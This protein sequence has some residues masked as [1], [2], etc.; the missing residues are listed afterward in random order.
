MKTVPSIEPSGDRTQGVGKRHPAWLL[1]V[2]VIGLTALAWS[3]RFVLDDAFI[4]LRYARNLARGEGLVWNAGEWVEGYTNFAWT[5]W[6]ALPFQLGVDPVLFSQL[7][8]LATFVVS[9]VAVWLAARA[10]L[11]DSTGALVAV[12]TLGMTP[13]FS[14]YATGGLETSLQAGLLTMAAALALQIW[15]STEVTPRSAAMLSATLGLAV[16][17]RMDS[18]VIGAWIGLGTLALLVGRSREGE[19]R[20]WPALL[21]LVLPFCSL[22]GVW[23]AWKV[24]VYGDVLPNTYYAKTGADGAWGRG[25]KFLWMYVESSLLYPALLASVAGVVHAV[26]ARHVPVLL[27]WGALGSWLLYVASVGGDF[28]EFRF[29]VAATPL[30]TLLLIWTLWTAV[31]SS[32]IRAIVVA[33]T[34]LGGLAHQTTFEGQD[35]VES[36]EQ[37]ASHLTHEV[38]DW[39][40][41]GKTLYADLGPDSDARIATTAAGAIPYF[42]DLPALDMLGLTD[43][44]VAT[45]GKRVSLQIAHNRLAPL[46]Y[47][48]ERDVHLVLGQPWLRRPGQP[49]RTGYPFEHLREL[50]ALQGEVARSFPPTTSVL[51][52]PLPENRVLVALYLTPHPD[53]DRAIA[54]SGWRRLPVVATSPDQRL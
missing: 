25:L 3:K 51:E 8:G 16:L 5:L 2:T 54:S 10:L 20:L 48:V 17:T 19:S 9:L 34:V 41:V 49:P 11:P 26:R 27:G 14:A 43:R 4:S 31:G 52:I 36:I 15:R 30:A 7:S 18:A 39:E 24:S 42:S 29:L 32:F 12:V 22:V 28:M 35:G 1:P 50:H 23:L 38:Q 44:W 33:C 37:L 13:T 46:D 6:L 47:M 40:G 21:A 53:V 45:N